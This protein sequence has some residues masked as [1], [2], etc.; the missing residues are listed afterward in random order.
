MFGFNRQRLE[1]PAFVWRM[2]P[3][4]RFEG[5]DCALGIALHGVIGARSHE[6][7]LLLLDSS[8]SR[9]YINPVVE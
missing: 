1:N 3:G 6:R 9:S 8:L 7:S 4:S 2:D 5:A